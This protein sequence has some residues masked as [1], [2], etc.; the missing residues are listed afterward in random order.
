METAPTEAVH[1]PISRHELIS[2]SPF[3]TLGTGSRRHGT[4]STRKI[5]SYGDKERRKLANS[6]V[7]RTRQDQ[8]RPNPEP[9]RE[10]FFL[11]SLPH[12]GRGEIPEGSPRAI[13]IASSTSQEEEHVNDPRKLW[14]LSDACLREKETSSLF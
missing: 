1:E 9:G 12:P 5:P 6:E 7:L 2:R 4:E 8:T 3:K 14:G 11:G 13:C 10:F